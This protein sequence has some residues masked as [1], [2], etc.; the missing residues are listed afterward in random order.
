MI[1]SKVPIS[2]KEFGDNYIA[3]GPLNESLIR[4][5]V[6]VIEPHIGALRRTIHSMRNRGINVYFVFISNFYSTQ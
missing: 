1:R 4:T 3:C 2:K 6:E 5:E